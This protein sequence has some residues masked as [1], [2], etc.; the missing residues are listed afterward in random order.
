[1]KK[2]IDEF[3]DQ[4]LTPAQK[5]YRRAERDGRLDLEKLREANRKF[6]ETDKGKACVRRANGKAAIRKI[7]ER[8]D[9]FTIESP[10][11]IAAMRLEIQRHLARGRDL[12][13]IAV[14]LRMPVAKIKSLLA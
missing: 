11:R 8:R 5:S 4:P 7:V 14:W 1:M 6:R 12:G 10:R 2:I 9:K 13:Q 3:T